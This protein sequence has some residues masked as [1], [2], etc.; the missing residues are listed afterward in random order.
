MDVNELISRLNEL[1]LKRTDFNPLW[2]KCAELCAENSR[3]Y[4]KDN[5]GRLEQK[6]FDSTA[7]LAKNSFS[8]SMKSLLV[9]TNQTWHRLKPTNPIFEKSNESRGYLQYANNL[10]FKMRYAADARFSAETD[11]LFDSIAI[12]GHAIWYIGDNG[13]GGT[14]YR[15]I[16]VNEAYIDVNDKNVVDTVFRKYELTAKNA[17]KKFGPRATSNMRERFNTDPDRKSEFLHAVLP[18]QDLKYGDHTYKGMPFASYHVDLQS[19]E[20]IYESG[21]RTMPYA[22]PRY[23]PI[24]GEVYARSPAS[25]AFFDILTVNEMTKTMLRVGQLQADPTMLASASLKSFKG[26]GQSHAIIPGGL[27]ENGRPRVAPMQYGGNLNITLEERQAIADIINKHFMVPLFQALTE[28]RTMTA[29]EI[30]ERKLEKAAMLAPISEKLG[31]EWLNPMILREL[32]IAGSY[33]Y[34]DGVPDELMQGGS[35]SI[36]YESPAVHMQSSGKIRGIYST[37][38]AVNIMAQ[39]KPEVIDKINYDRAIDLI[40]DYNGVPVDVM[41]T[42]EEL[43]KIKQSRAEQAQAQMALEATPMIADVAQKVGNIRDNNAI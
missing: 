5:R 1:E 39:S 19:K 11:I 33:G 31:V 18:R 21:Y 43:E 23:Q 30:E 7:V 10:L 24:A 8:A 36:E 40:A 25:N 4:I 35:I 9:P 42:P 38:E 3:I 26:I 32:D 28:L 41:S 2:D 20:I 37:L 12:Y 34:L 16:P 6:V 27:D 15:C 29:T 14:Y 13:K 22:V 17:L